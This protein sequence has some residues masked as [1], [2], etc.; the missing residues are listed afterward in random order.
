MYHNL[1]GRVKAL[2]KIK[3][4]HRSQMKKVK[5]LARLNLKEADEK[6]FEVNFNKKTVI[7]EA[8]DSPIRCGFEAETQNQTMYYLRQT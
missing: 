5:R 6:L 2:N 7:E 4:K 1:H 8:L 3:P